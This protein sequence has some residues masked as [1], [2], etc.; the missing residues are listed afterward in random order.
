L[1]EKLSE[2]DKIL[3]NAV[4]SLALVVEAIK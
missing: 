2:Q 1:Q 3:G 4:P